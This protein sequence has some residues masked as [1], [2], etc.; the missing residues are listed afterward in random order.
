MDKSKPTP[1]KDIIKKVFG[2]A[3]KNPEEDQKEIPQEPEN[4][5]GSENIIGKENTSEEDV[6]IPKAQTEDLN[7]EIEDSGSIPDI[8]PTEIEIENIKE[9]PTIDI[10]D[11][12]TME[13]EK[14]EIPEVKR[15]RQKSLRNNH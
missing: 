5:V 14:T 1:L 6:E 11:S 4:V 9:E 3:G 12:L 15:I 13:G 2:L 10:P 8:Q 7:P